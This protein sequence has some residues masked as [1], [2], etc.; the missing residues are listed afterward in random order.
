M[1]KSNSLVIVKHVRHVPDVY[2]GYH[3]QLNY[4]FFEN[5]ESDHTKAAYKS[6]LNQFFGFVSHTFGPMRSIDD[7]NRS[8]VIAYRNYLQ[9][10]GGRKGKPCCPKTVIRRLAAV[11]SY[12]D[13][14]IEKGFMKLNP[15]SSVRRPRDEVITATQDLTDDQVRRLIE[16][17]DTN[18]MSGLL[19]KA[20]LTLMFSTGLRKSELIHLKVG[21]YRDLNGYKIVQFIGKRGKVSR[22]PLHPT[23]SYHLDRYILWMKDQGRAMSAD[24]WLFQPTRN[25]SD[26]G[27]ITKK[28]S[29]GSVD[30]IIK[31]YC[32]KVGIDARITPHSARATVIGSLLEH[33]C[34]LYKVS[35]L[36][37]HS[38]VKT[39]QS[40]DKRGK[41]ISDSPVFHLK[42]F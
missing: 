13:F 11:K 6:D 7:L 10:N 37:N 5:F 1:N 29:A 19:H 12:C 41:K 23:A 28:L 22:V 31:R 36:V 20:I 16:A 38:N 2:E 3:S 35:Q 14:L 18:K 27:H 25:H 32:R 33:G 4:E 8:H 17:V 15:T 34:D 9:T 21:D 40:Y 26:N 39:T 30:F 24:D 42:F